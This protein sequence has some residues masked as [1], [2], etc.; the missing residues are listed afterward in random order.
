MDNDV[1]GSGTGRRA[2]GLTVFGREVIAELE[3]QGVIVDLAHMSAPGI[4]QTLPLLTRPFTLSHG[5]LLRRAAAA[6]PG[7]SAATTRRRA[8]CP[9]QW[10][11]RLARAAGCSAS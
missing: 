11:A 10:R 4:E 3:S 1:V 8:T 5:A 2:G 6:R 7:A 9:G